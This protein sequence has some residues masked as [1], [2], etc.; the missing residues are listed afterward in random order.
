[1]DWDFATALEKREHFIA[2]GMTEI[3]LHDEDEPNFPWGHVARVESGGCYRGGIPTGARFLAFIEGLTFIWSVD[4]DKRDA[5]RRSVSPFDR[6]R[7]REIYRLLPPSARYTLRNLLESEFLP[8]MV[9]QTA[10]ARAYLNTRADSEDC[11]RGL[12]SWAEKEGIL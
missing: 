12:I 9:K 3:W 7:V 6:E 8:E 11:V 10:E 5:D 4:F 1:M 2:I